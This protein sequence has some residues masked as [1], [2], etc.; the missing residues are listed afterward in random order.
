MLKMVD[1]SEPRADNRVEFPRRLSGYRAG[2]NIHRLVRSGG[3]LTPLM[4]STG[5]IVRSD[6]GRRCAFFPMPLLL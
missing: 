5:P 2:P 6:D 4:Y 1:V 3:F